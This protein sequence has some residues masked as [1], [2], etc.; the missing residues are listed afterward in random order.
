MEQYPSLFQLEASAVELDINN[1]QSYVMRQQH[2]STTPAERLALHSA[3]KCYLNLTSMNR[4]TQYGGYGDSLSASAPKLPEVASQC[5]ACFIAISV[6]HSVH[7]GP[8]NSSLI[9][10]DSFR[11]T[12][13]GEVLHEYSPPGSY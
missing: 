10:S 7:I 3:I 1:A 6:R 5:T 8:Q 12:I 11:N 9:G 13:T 2:R 4:L